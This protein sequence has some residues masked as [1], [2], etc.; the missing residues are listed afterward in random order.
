MSRKRLNAPEINPVNSSPSALPLLSFPLWPSTIAALVTSARFPPTRL[1]DR[2]QKTQESATEISE[3]HIVVFFSALFI[4][5]FGSWWFHLHPWRFFFTSLFTWAMETRRVELIHAQSQQLSEF[6][7]L[8]INYSKIKGMLMK[9]LLV[10]TDL[11]LQTE[12]VLK[13][14]G[15]C[16]EWKIDDKWPCRV[17]QHQPDRKKTKL[18]SRPRGIG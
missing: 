17:L 4:T 13:V 11:T 3:H 2:D 14:C 9:E 18:I 12:P 15:H 8:I 16:P 1:Q 10:N 7:S 5:I 6:S